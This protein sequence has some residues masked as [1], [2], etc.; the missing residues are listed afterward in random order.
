MKINAKFVIF[1][2][3]L[4]LTSCTD[5]QV[6]SPKQVITIGRQIVSNHKLPEGDTYEDNAYTRLVENELNIDLLS[7][8]EVL[9]ADYSKRISTCISSK[10]LPDIMQVDSLEQL[11]E[12][13]ENDLIADLSNVYEEYATQ[14][15]KAKYDSYNGKCFEDVTIDNK[16]IALPNTDLLE[17]PN[18]VWIRSDWIDQ[19]ELEIDTNNDRK[20]SI[21]ELEFIASSFVKA[22]LAQSE[23]PVGIASTTDVISDKGDN[24]YCLNQVA[25]AMGAMP[26]TWYLNDKNEVEY[27][28]ITDE[29][30]DFLIL[31]NRWYEEGILD[32]QFATRTWDD[33]QQL[34]ID[35]ATGI[36]FGAWHMPDWGLNNV[37]SNFPNATFDAFALENNQGKIYSKYNQPN[38]SYIVVSK[39]CETPEIAIQILNLLNDDDLIKQAA[40]DYPEIEEYQKLAVDGS[41]RPFNIVVVSETSLLDDYNDVLIGLSGEISYEQIKTLESKAVISSID[42][43]INNTDSSST[44][45]WA[46]YH[47]RLL[48]ISLYNDLKENNDYIWIN[49]INVQTIKSLQQNYIAL[50]N[51][52]TEF[53]IQVI[54]G[55]IDPQQ[56]F[57]DFVFDWNEQGGKDIVNEINSNLNKN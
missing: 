30:L 14:G 28:T 32:P 21:E 4:L 12:L 20:I 7:E 34:L 48:G 33:V 35:G 9:Q 43:Y 26:K 16:L 36:A 31:L 5:K 44:A 2:M 50:N 39:E 51:L 18:I 23:T 56:G 19:L 49:P 24:S 41:T 45:D 55:L 38:S 40:L 17:S 42:N 3:I 37:L 54:L 8:F 53:F 6:H 25:Y 1:P 13:Y 15:I 10:K 27:G 29:T 22:N 52:E 47:S 11:Y 57:E 46:K